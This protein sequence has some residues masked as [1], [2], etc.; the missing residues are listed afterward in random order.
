MDRKQAIDMYLMTNAK[1]FPPMSIPMVQDKLNSLN[2]SQMM[3]I[4]SVEI[5]DPTMILV[6]SLVAGA[7]GVDR[8]LIGDIGMGLF[9]LLT[10]GGCGV[11]YIIDWFF[12][13]KRTREKNLQR[14]MS[15]Y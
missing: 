8:F 15:I 10:A 5:K 6:V 2:E 3:S 14:L 13:S 11:F 4:G 1:N 7:L 12:I 9:K